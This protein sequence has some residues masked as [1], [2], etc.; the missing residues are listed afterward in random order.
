MVPTRGNISVQIFPVNSPAVVLARI[1]LSTVRLSRIILSRVRLSR[2][3]LVFEKS[4]IEEDHLDQSEEG[5][6][7][8]RDTNIVT[9][10]LQ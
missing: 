7:D 6:E 9:V 8:G 10:Q 4:D 3:N 5:V 2:V 1:T